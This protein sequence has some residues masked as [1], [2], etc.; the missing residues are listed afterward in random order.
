VPNLTVAQLDKIQ[1][2]SAPLS[3][4]R[5]HVNTPILHKDA[6]SETNDYGSTELVLEAKL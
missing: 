2:D 6:S 4:R 3:A 5:I 1:L